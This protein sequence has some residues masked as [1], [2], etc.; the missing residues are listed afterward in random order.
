[1]SA[2]GVIPFA[3]LFFFPFLPHKMLRKEG[4]FLFIIT[5]RQL[6]TRFLTVLAAILILL[7]LCK[8]VPAAYDFLVSN[9]EEKGEFDELK[10]PVRV[11]LDGDDA[12][13]AEW[14]NVFGQ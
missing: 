1:M 10:D 6:K 13:T 4:M 5:L 2:G 14:L 7:C 11:E 8:G 3:D 12:F 9:A